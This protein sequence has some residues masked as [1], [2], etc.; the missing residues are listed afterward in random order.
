MKKDK[1]IFD[2]TQNMS[3]LLL[4]NL[5]VSD[6]LEICSQVSKNCSKLCD[7]I[8]KNIQQG[9]TLAYSIE[10]CSFVKFPSFY[11]NLIGIAQSS[12]EI[13]SVF[14]ELF[15]YLQTERKN[16]EKI[17]QSLLYPLFVV[18]STI[19]VAV[20]ILAYVYPKFSIILGEF[21]LENSS[22]ESSMQKSLFVV[23]IFI[24][25]FIFLI[26]ISVLIFVS[27]KRFEE[28]KLICSKII[29]I[30][31]GIGK[32]FCYRYT[33]NLVFSLNLLCKN[34]INFVEALK[35][36]SNSI[37]NVAYSLEVKILSSKISSGKSL[38]VSL[39]EAK[40]FPEHFS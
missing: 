35:C 11:K 36:A 6:S 17:V 15:S 32:Y 5:N 14:E 37:S 40:Y 38:N 39:D 3:S 8:L 21:C 9:K 4:G 27:Y 25:F 33:K 16:R 20:F 18:F 29:L 1:I 30:L 2:F 7:F 26:V 13:S 10:N 22:L 23:K 19:C 24:C 34:G 28:A 31:P 12:G